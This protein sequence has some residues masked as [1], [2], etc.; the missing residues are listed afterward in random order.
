MST[1]QTFDIESDWVHIQYPETSAFRDVYG[2]A[3]Q[4]GMVNIEGIRLR[5]KGKPSKTLLFY[6]HPAST[7]QI[8]PVPK[9][10]AAGGAHVLCAGSRYARND[11]PLILE[12]VLMDIAAYFRHAK[13]VWGYEKIVL[14]G[15]SGGASLSMTYQSQAEH[16]T[17]QATPAG[18]PIALKAMNPIAADGVIWQAG[19]LARAVVLLDFIDPSV[20]D[21][22]NP[23]R[24]DPR[25]DLYHPGNQGPYTAD[26]VTEFRAAQL[27]RMRRRTAWVKQ[28]LEDLRKRG[29]KE[30][31]RGFIT[32]R[33]LAD[34]RWLD[35][36][37]D[38]TTAWWAP[39]GWVTPKPSTPGPSRWAGFPP[40]ARGCRNGPSKTPSAIRS[41]T[42]PTSACPF[43]RLKTPPTTRC[44]SPTPN[45]FMTW[46]RPKTKPCRSSKAPTTTTWAS[47]N[48]CAK[49]WTCAFSGC[50]NAACRTDAHAQ[51]RLRLRP[52]RHPHPLG[53]VL[54]SRLCGWAQR[55]G[56]AVHRTGRVQLPAPCDDPRQGLPHHPHQ[57]L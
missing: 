23:D 47:P 35:G 34:P 28:Q 27:A 39:A 38:P 53:A 21:E 3:S 8:L 25:L 30:V 11:T 48:T 44:P 57:L 45:A 50:A 14:V 4:S 20:I 18:E 51:T 12:K 32:H 24:R 17:I 56:L 5:P 16:T 7:L 42:R 22:D 49:P 29:G 46:S 13:E 1:P 41:T 10:M 37:I 2:F 40:C 36:S 55:R 6:M 9:S 31:E 15:W 54:V 43:W 52:D 19:H 26:F 33:T